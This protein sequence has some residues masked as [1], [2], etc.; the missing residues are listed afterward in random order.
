MGD[1]P[2]E[3]TEDDELAAVRA[4]AR[5]VKVQAVIVTAIVAGIAWIL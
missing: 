3:I 4:Q 2:Q 1:G 5:R